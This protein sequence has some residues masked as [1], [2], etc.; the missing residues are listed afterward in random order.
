[1]GA[2]EE[3]APT[4]PPKAALAEVA[5]L[6]TRLGF[7]AFGGPA[8]HVAMLE[9][10]VVKRRKWLSQQEF[11]D[12]FSVSG[13]IPGPTSTELVIHLGMTR[14]GRPGLL[15]AGF[16]FITPAVLL[17]SLLAWGYVT[18]GRLPAAEGMLIGIKPAVVAVVFQAVARLA[19]SAA[20]TAWL[21][22]IA[23]LIAGL[24]LVG[25]N[26]LALLLGSGLFGIFLSRP[27]KAA[28]SAIALPLLAQAGGATAAG[29][30][31]ASGTLGIFLY[32]LKLGSMLFGS[33]YVLLAFLR[34]GLGHELGPLTERQLMDAVAAGQFTPG[35]LFSTAA[36]LG[37]LLGGWR[38][39]AAASV[40]IFLPSFILVGATHGIVKRLR[41][42]PWSAGFMDGLNA[43]SVGLM[44]GVLIQLAHAAMGVVWTWPILL[45]AAILLLRTKT[46]PAWIVITAGLLGIAAHA[47]RPL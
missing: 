13:M 15:L 24:Y 42:A 34:H 43:G 10:E 45:V 28:T 4:H 17:T 3:A 1:M 18:F 14:A 8:A 29:G 7:T 25:V 23:V 12:F 16:C 40:G 47:V 19:K 36:F 33:G 44:A 35:P 2:P 26:E 21:A 20:K 6:M 9:E 46:N 27:P 31:A 30:A 41:D 39:A 22:L 11:L 5:L 32:F 38:G 37:F